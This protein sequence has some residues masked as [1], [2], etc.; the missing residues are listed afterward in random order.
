MMIPQEHD[1]QSLTASLIDLL[2]TDI[3][4]VVEATSTLPPSAVTG[5]H[6]EVYAAI[7]AAVT[8]S[9]EPTR[10][11]VAAKLKETGCGQ[12][13]PPYTIFIEALENRVATGSRAAAVAREAAERLAQ[14]HA[15]REAQAAAERF[16]QSNG[17]PEAQ[18]E[19]TAALNA[20]KRPLTASRLP[21]DLDAIDAVARQET[22]PTVP[23]GFSWLD[24]GTDGGLPIGGLV[25]LIA[26]PGCGKSALALQWC[27]GA[28]VTDSDLRIVWGLGEMSLP[29]IARRLVT[30][31]SGF[32][33][34]CEPVT[35]VEAA[36][37]TQRASKARAGV[38][39]MSDGR[40]T[41]VQPPLTVAAIDAAI[42]RTGAKL[43][44]CDYLQLVSVPDGGRD[45]V[46]DLD[47]TIGALRDMAIRRE[48]AVIVVSSMAKATG[49]ASR[50]GQFA[51]GSAELDYACDLLFVGETEEK[52]GVP[53]V[54]ADGTTGVTWRC[55]KARN[56]EPRDLV[57]RFDGARQTYR[58]A[59]PPIT[60]DHALAAWN[61]RVPA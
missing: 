32:V 4:T 15:M 8:E 11:L 59:V 46:A 3:G 13:S 19:M 24:R 18:A 47:R 30:V 31:A 25:A 29:A 1:E 41:F 16:K 60:Q 56:G 17:G 54:E 33:D 7:V 38:A 42:S 20:L 21:T 34:G 26:P 12:G 57:L 43:A 5:E 51:R 50:A 53:V 2:D 45:R 27:A 49:S 61:E 6:A 10:A 23:T 44:V 37:K 58:S 14:R 52:N 39:G 48:C 55:R 9:R 36:S 28:L 22:T 40:I 35:M